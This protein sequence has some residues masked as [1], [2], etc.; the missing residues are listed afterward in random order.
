MPEQWQQNRRDTGRETAASPLQRFGAGLCF[1]RERRGDLALWSKRPGL[2]PQSSRNYYAR[3]RSRGSA[4]S[5]SLSRGKNVSHCHI[6][7]APVRSGQSPDRALI[8]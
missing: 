7:P 4:A 3:S 2:W 5:R 1:A 6:R 8:L